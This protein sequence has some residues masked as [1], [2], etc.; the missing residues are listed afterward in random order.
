MAGFESGGERGSDPESTGY[1]E[2]EPMG[3]RDTEP[4]DLSSELALT[5]NGGEPGGGRTGLSSAS[6][7]V[8]ETP[9]GATVSSGDFTSGRAL[10][11]VASAGAVPS[12]FS[13]PFASVSLTLPRRDM[14]Q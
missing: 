11:D 1:R 3:G 7:L 6:G 13:V 2:D 10:G 4:L 9:E 14:V 8:A 5:A 12:F